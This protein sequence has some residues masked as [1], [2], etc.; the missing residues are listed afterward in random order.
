MGRARREEGGERGKR[1]N[2]SFLPWL[3]K[4]GTFSFRRLSLSSSPFYRHPQISSLEVL[5]GNN[6][7]HRETMFL[8]VEVSQSRLMPFDKTPLLT[9][10]FYFPWFSDS[11]LS[12]SFRGILMELEKIYEKLFFT[13]ASDSAEV[14]A[15]VFKKSRKC[16]FFFFSFFP[17]WKRVLQHARLYY[18]VFTVYTR[19]WKP[20]IGFD[21]LVSFWDWIDVNDKRERMENGSTGD[22]E[23]DGCKDVILW[24]YFQREKN[25]IG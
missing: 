18:H 10:C 11:L 21:A 14:S 16:F 25:F 5:R 20:W 12:L 6:S 1:G 9:G 4:K 24:K 19:L 15:E 13:S 2:R 17:F 8:P 23:K 22:K 7:R 3:V